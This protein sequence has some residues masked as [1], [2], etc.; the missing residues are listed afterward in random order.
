MPLYSQGYSLARFLIAQGGKRKYLDYLS[1]GLKNE[2]W[3]SVTKK[4]YGFESLGQLQNDWLDWVRQGSPALSPEAQAEQA[5][6]VADAGRRPRPE[7]NLIYRGQ[8][9]DLPAKTPPSG[10]LVPVVPFEQPRSAPPPQATARVEPTWPQQDAPMRSA[11]PIPSPR[12]RVLLEW[13]RPGE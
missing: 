9:E 10:P 8:S 13:R 3:T 1:D 11:E 5:T 4:H 7:P 2:Q 12:N 6:S